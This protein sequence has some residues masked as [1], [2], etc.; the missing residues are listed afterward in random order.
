MLANGGGTSIYF[1]LDLAKQQFVFD[2]LKTWG[3]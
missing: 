2:R 1:R 3:I